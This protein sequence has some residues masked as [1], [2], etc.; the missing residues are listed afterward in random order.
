MVDGLRWIW[1]SSQCVAQVPMV[2]GAM[3]GSTKEPSIL[4]DSTLAR[5]RST[6]ALRAKDLFTV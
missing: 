1:F 4:A 2:S 5:N 6:S 3:A